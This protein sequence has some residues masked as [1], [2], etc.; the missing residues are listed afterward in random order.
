M[1][2]TAS[3]GRGMALQRKQKDPEKLVRNAQSGAQPVGR[4]KSQPWSMLIDEGGR[5]PGRRK[6]EIPSQ[7]EKITDRH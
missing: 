1:R 3:R 5:K 4:K 6:E 2:R 7:S